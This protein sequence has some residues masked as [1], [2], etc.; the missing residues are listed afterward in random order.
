MKT[1]FY[2]QIATIIFSCML[3]V[4][5]NNA[6]ASN[7]TSQL[8]LKMVDNTKFG[9]I[10]DG[11]PMGDVTFNFSLG[12]ILPGKHYLKIIKIRKSKR[13][14]YPV[15]IYSGFIEI[16]S[17]SSMYALVNYNS[18]IDIVDVKPLY[19][20]NCENDYDQYEILGYSSV[21]DVTVVPTCLPTYT[22]MN[23]ISFQQLKS[24]MA[25]KPF[26]SAKLQIAKQAVAMNKVTAAQVSELVSMF[27]FESYKL[28]FAKYAYENTADKQNYFRIHDQ[29]TFSSSVK[30]LSN[31]LGYN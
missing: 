13:G 31:Y 24:S 27:T 19:S 4:L 29:F 8:H 11:N 18:G 12:N 5:S 22:G 9:V 20:L 10:L 26:D 28:D 17:N 2:K 30:E 21:S 3:A 14:R 16:P 23:P 6:I 7:F 1:T 25:S 15:A